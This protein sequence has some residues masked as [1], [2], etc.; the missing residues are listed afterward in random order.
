MKGKKNDFSMT[1]Y[2]FDKKVMHLH[3]VHNTV[4]A[5]QWMDAKNITWGHAN[6]YERRSGKYLKRIYH[7]SILDVKVYLSKITG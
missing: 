4:K 6:I 5:V 7:Q 1:F 2:H 3:F